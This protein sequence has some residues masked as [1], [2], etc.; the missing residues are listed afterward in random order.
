MISM[1]WVPDEHQHDIILGLKDLRVKCSNKIVAGY[2]NINSIRNKFELLSSLIGGTIYILMI[3]ETKS[4][5]TFSTN[6]FFIQ[7]YSTVH[8]MDRNDKGREIILFLKDDIIT[9]PLERYSFPLG[10]EVFYRGL[11]LRKKKC[12]ILFASITL[13][14]DSLNMIS[15][16]WE[17]P[18]N[19]TRK[20]LKALY[21]NAEISETNLAF[22]TLY[23]FKSL[24]CFKNPDNPFCID[25]ILTNCP[26]YFQNSSTF[27]TGLSDFHKLIL[28]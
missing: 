24:I 13:A 5:L 14:I 11:N 8:R 28:T 21:F 20:R 6:Q 12:V 2:L 25:L 10:F 1:N 4:D 9:F 23:N 17:E 7:G 18:L 3:S 27:E 22:F 19:F 15:N 16:N 26:N